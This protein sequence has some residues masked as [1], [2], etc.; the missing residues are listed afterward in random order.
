M[1][2]IAA[3]L[4]LIAFVA[5]FFF[6]G[7]SRASA[8]PRA[9]RAKAHEVA[10][11]G[12]TC[13]ACVAR[14]ERAL[15]R[16][17]GVERAEV[18][19]ATES[20]RVW[21]A[22]EVGLDQVLAAIDNS[23][24]DARP[25]SA[26]DPEARDAEKA[27]ET[28][29]LGARLLA[30]SVCTAPL[31]VFG[32]HI[33]GVPMLDHRVQLVLA[34]VVLGWSGNRFFVLAAKALRS[35]FAD[36]NVLIAL[37]TGAAF[38]Y[39]AVVT[40]FPAQLHAAG[41][42]T[43]KVYFEVAA[44]IITL[45]LLGRW[46]EARAKGRT[47]D[48]IRKLLALQA[49]TA[50]VL[51]DGQEVDAP[52]ESLRVGERVLVRPGE[53]V[54]VDGRILEGES[55]LDE[56]LLTGESLPLDKGPGDK[57]YGGSQ[58]GHG[59]FWMEATG[60]GRDTA[61]ARIVRLVAQAQGSRAPIQRLADRITAVFVPLVLMVAVVTFTGWWL[62]GY[63]LAQALIPTVAVLIIACPCALGLATPMA[64]MVAT[65]RAAQL[66]ILVRDAEALERLA[67]ANA[68]VLDKTG[69]LTQGKPEVTGVVTA[70]G[71]PEDALALA[72]AVE[73]AS[74]H[75]LARAVVAAAAA[76][77]LRL[78]AA[79][80]VRAHPGAG[81]TG[82]I[83]DRA[84][85]IGSPRWVEAGALQGSVDAWAA[86][87]RTAM[88]MSA[89]GEPVAAFGIADQPKPE[90]FEAVSELRALGLE[91]W[92][93]TGDN[94]ATARAIGAQVGI[95][96]VLA[97]AKPEDKALEVARLRR[98]GWRV[99]MAGDGINDAPALTAAEV[100]IAMGGGADVALES[101]DVALLRGDLRG[102]PRA[103]RL[104]RA[105]LRNIKQNYLF[106]FGYNTLAIPLAALGYLSPI[107]ASIA[108][109]LSSV[110]VVT[111]AL[112]LRRFA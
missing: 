62:A 71:A 110:H 14:V 28:R 57:V 24:Y 69:T 45:V 98:E 13:A 78:P 77:G 74:E 55:A 100:G 91:P 53:R 54:P 35:R 18:N 52:I 30:A 83:E 38:A 86:E 95:E 43:H 8:A 59:A 94:Q 33:P 12:M 109:A 112:R 21:S 72:A 56:S 61:L 84:V 36:M 10:V 76:K 20:A 19:L 11:G 75:P 6:A 99:A 15:L 3:A 68:M 105:M 17:P 58:N 97:E 7:G 102:L 9:G 65:G 64:V 47:G 46:L 111:N 49:K 51:R 70:S 104:G 85:R 37:G 79:S 90:A 34:L 42:H 26:V 22:P 25:A 66:G 92:M 39:S 40:L 29:A 1:I 80:Q 88:V 106:A 96:N 73:S 48:A 103:V 4:V 50:R 107:I 82:V 23:G 27:A 63:G 31:L 44:A 60:V 5:W 108:M 16:L 2:P 67:K 101:A 93:I 41:I 32:M 89:D 87:G 81:V